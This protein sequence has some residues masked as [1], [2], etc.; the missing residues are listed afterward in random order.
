MS[1]NCILK[2]RAEYKNATVVVYL[3]YIYLRRL[4]VAYWVIWIL[5][6][7]RMVKNHYVIN[8]NTIYNNILYCIYLSHLNNIL[9]FKKL[10]SYIKHN[11][12]VYFVLLII[13]T[14]LPAHHPTTSATANYVYFYIILWFAPRPHPIAYIDIKMAITV[15][16]VPSLSAINLMRYKTFLCVCG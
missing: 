16:N 11:K 7:I 15:L 4:R 10:F 8:H 1:T 5:W 3:F 13:S 12:F 14:P 2:T 6:I 9:F